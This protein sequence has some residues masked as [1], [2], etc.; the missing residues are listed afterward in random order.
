[1]IWFCGRI[2][3]LPIEG[4]WCAPGTIFL[5][6][7]GEMWVFRGILG[8]RFFIF[9]VGG[10]ALLVVGGHRRERLGNRLEQR[11][12]SGHSIGPAGLKA[13]SPQDGQGLSTP[14]SPSR[15]VRS[16]GV[17]DKDCR[18]LALAES[19]GVRS[20]NNAGLVWKRTRILQE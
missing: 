16:D 19:L 8:K 17:N 7:S 1:M 9:E 4:R 14:P 5:R 2:L 6:R 11:E 13:A 15:P 12:E 18:P 20:F 10:V 3:G